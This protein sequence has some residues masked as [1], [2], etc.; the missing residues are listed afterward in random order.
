MEFDWTQLGLCFT[1]PRI[2]SW[3]KLRAEKE[4][5][6][7]A[8]PGGLPGPLRMLLLTPATCSVLCP[9]LHLATNPVITAHV[10]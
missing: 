7:L 8:K 10:T 9:M 5:A 1:L 2:V 6:E 3:N 4:T